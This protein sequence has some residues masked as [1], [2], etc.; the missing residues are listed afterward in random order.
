VLTPGHWARALQLQEPFDD[1]A[2]ACEVAAHGM[3][4]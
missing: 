2:D 3:P 4:A 1:E